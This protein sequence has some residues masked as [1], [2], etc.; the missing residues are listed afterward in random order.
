LNSNTPPKLCASAWAEMSTKK[1]TW[2]CSRN[3]RVSVHFQSMRSSI[4]DKAGLVHVLQ[5]LCTRDN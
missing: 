2:S 4:R 3:K 5:T 1:S